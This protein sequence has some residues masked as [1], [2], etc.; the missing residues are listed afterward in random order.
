M[1]AALD[2]V[3]AERPEPARNEPAGMVGGE[4]Q[5]GM[6]RRAAGRAPAR[7][8]V[9]EREVAELLRA[10]YLV[11]AGPRI[12]PEVIRAISIPGSIPGVIRPRG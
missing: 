7:R 1:P 9:G 6:R 11:M 12:K 8:L 3:E 10:T 5:V 2:F 4:H